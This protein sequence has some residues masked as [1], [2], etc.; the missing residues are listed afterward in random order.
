MIDDKFK[1]FLK[2]SFIYFIVVY[3]N[4]CAANDLSSCT[5]PKNQRHNLDVSFD[6]LYWHAS[7]TFD[8]AFTLKSSQ[9]STQSSFKTFKFD[10]DTG[11]RV[12]LGYN[13][14]HDKW[15][16]HI[17]YTRF[18]SNANDHSLGPIT[19]AFLASRLS[20]LEPFS[21]GKANLKLDYN[22]F[23]WYLGKNILITKSILLRLSV[24]IRGGWINQAVYSDW[25]NPDFLFIFFVTAKENLKQKFKAVGPKVGINGKWNFLNLQKQFFSFISEFNI[26][27]LWGH[28]AIKD[29]F[30][31]TFETKISVITNQRNYGAFALH[32]F[33]GF[34]WDYNFSNKVDF[35]LKLGYEIEDWLNQLQIFTDASGSQN[36]DLILQGFNFGLGLNF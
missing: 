13:I 24:G 5:F 16:T 35:R 27:Y 19:P 31:D 1:I 21:S 26:Y 11:F 28:W 14:N 34:G 9:N 36:N 8:W 6:A 17:N 12:G 7:E 20:L 18:Q 29:K 33:M 23:D 22:M 15:D 25:V 2:V 30:I 10:W 3:C 4:L 32:G